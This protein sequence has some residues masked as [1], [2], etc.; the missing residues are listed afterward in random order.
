METVMAQFGVNSY[1]HAGA[2][3]RAAAAGYS[4]AAAARGRSARSLALLYLFRAVFSAVWIA[5]VASLASAAAPGAALS[6]LASVLLVIYP[7]SD[8]VATVFDLRAAPGRTQYANLVVSLAATAGVVI[9]LPYGLAPAITVFGVWAIASGAIMV[10]VAL[11]RQSLGRQSLGRQSLGRRSLGRRSL[12]RRSLGGQWP[13][14]VSG[15]GSVLA[16][17]TFVGWAGSSTAGL[18]T[19]AQYSAGGALWYLLAAIW[20]LWSARWA[21][22]RG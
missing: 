7:L 1:D 9:A 16:G 11:R 21:A 13:M 18:D 5:V 6:T 3:R 20:L 2:A 17:I 8:A 10:V 15:A 22:A 12:G 19:L 14:I 4:A